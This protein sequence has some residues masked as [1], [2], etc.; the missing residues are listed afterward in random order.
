MSIKWLRALKYAVLPLSFVFTSGN[1]DEKGSG[2][3][4]RI[5]ETYDPQRDAFADLEKAKQLAAAD[6]RRILLVVGGKWCPFCRAIEAFLDKSEPV[7]KVL[8]EHFVIMKVNV[9]DETS[10]TAFLNPYPAIEAYPHLFFLDEKGELM[11]S[12]DTG[13][14]E[15]QSAG[16]D[17][18]AFVR[19]LQA[20][21][22]GE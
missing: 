17:E 8:A 14:L 19:I 2:A 16:Y 18:E 20:Q 4:Y 5:S 10:N 13:E 9:S 11:H 21:V 3:P 15:K 22:K 7:S 6:N 1:A 12:Q